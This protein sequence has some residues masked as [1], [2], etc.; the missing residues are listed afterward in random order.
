[1]KNYIVRWRGWYDAEGFSWSKGTKKNATRLTRQDARARAAYLG[2]E[3]RVVKLVSKK[4]YVVKCGKLYDVPGKWSNSQ[5]RATRY[6]RAEAYRQAS[7]V[8][9]KA[10][11]VKLVR[12]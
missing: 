6:Y 9:G 11:V 3:A 8:F 4:R 10:R 7:Y 12:K 5:R 1:M 2:S